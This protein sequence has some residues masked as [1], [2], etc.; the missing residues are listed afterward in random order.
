MSSQNQCLSTAPAV[1][2]LQLQDFRSYKRLSLDLGSA[3]FLALCGE[4]GAGKTNIL[5]ALSLFT[6]GKGLRRAELGELARAAGDGSFAVSLELDCDLGRVRLGT[7]SNPAEGPG[8]KHRI[9]LQP[10]S[11]ARAFSDYLRII[12]LTPSMDGLFMG[13]GSERRRFLDR[14]VLSVDS[15]HAA[16]VSA[17]ERAL[18][19]RNRLLEERMPDAAWLDATEQEIAE[20]AI[21]IAIAR[22]D[23]V[24]R[25]QQIIEIGKCVETPFPWASVSLV[26]EIDELVRAQTA[27]EA[28]DRY[29]SMLRES[30]RRDAAAGRT[31]VGPQ[32]SDLKVIHGPKR[33][34][35]DRCSTGEQ[36]A[37]LVGLILAHANLVRASSG[38][39][40]IALLDEVMA[41]F[42]PQRRI[43]LFNI[44]EQI[45]CQVWVTGADPQAFADMPRSGALIRVTA[46]S[47]EVATPP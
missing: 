19:N 33:M 20:T 24:D 13:P 43:A 44:L 29:R 10:A 37:L 31:L 9:D 36:K 23:T 21:A 4:N 34:Q 18:R 40:P 14:M 47:A 22:C 42:D 46:G 25:L 26:G 3:M 41:H 45:G 39:A 2:K 17:L 6:P 35:A 38:F 15:E 12:W 1:R 27:L 32:S 5:E 30:R 7:G 11:S 28:E 8:R 16:R